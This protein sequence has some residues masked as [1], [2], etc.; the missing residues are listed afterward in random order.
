MA[1]TEGKVHFVDG[2]GCGI[3]VLCCEL[4]DANAG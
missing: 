3:G 4:P 1:R 2:G